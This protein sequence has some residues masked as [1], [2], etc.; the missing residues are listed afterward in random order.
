[1]LNQ[2]VRKTLRIRD[3]PYPF[4]WHDRGTQ[5]NHHSYDVVRLLRFGWPQMTLQERA[6]AQAEMFIITAR[7]RR[8]S[9]NSVGE[10]DLS[11]YS[12]IDE[13]YYFGVS[14][15][16]EIGY[17]RKSKG[18]WIDWEPEDGDELR[19]LILAAI[20]RLGVKSPMM[21]GA[22]RKLLARD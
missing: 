13:A 21:D 22:R 15:F 1:M 4:G 19:K 18:F 17:F 8:L 3:R 14:L 10:F 16:D 12:S 6:K 9:I 7:A 20:D 11:P 5:N 2:L